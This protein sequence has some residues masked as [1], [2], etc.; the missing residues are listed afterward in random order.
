MI[1]VN[2]PA[3][4]HDDQVAALRLIDAHKAG[5]VVMLLVQTGV[6][7]AL[8]P[9]IVELEGFKSNP[10]LA[11]IPVSAD[12]PAVPGAVYEWALEQRRAAGWCDRA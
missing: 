11:L 6:L 9:A 1:R 12:L 7:R 10:P 4:M 3:H 5:G 2:R 8:P